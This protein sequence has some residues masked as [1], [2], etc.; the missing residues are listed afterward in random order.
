MPPR[1]GYITSR[2]PHLPETFILREMVELERQGWE[3]RL[4]PLINQNQPI[5]HDEAAYFD[6]NAYHA[7]YLSRKILSSNLRL[8]TRSPRLFTQTWRR[9]MMENIKD[10]KLFVRA[11][12][13]LPKA[14][15]IAQQMQL[16]QVQHIHAH[17]ATHP[18][19]VAWIIH[20]VTGISYSITAHAHDIYVHKAM[21]AT[22]LRDAAFI[23]AISNFNREYMARF[24]GEWVLDKTHV[25]HCGIDPGIFHPRA[26]VAPPSGDKPFQIIHTG[27][28]QPY[29]GQSYLVEACA[30]LMERNINFRCR[31]IGGGEEFSRL[32]SQI[33]KRGL[34]NHVFLEG[35]RK[36]TEVAQLLPD[37]D[38]YVQ[39]SIITTSGKM[40]GI[41]VAL[42]EAM[43]CKLPC[44]AT[45]IS[46]VPELVRHQE[47]GL[48][49]QPAN[50]VDLANALMAI[51][52]NPQ[53]SWQMA[54]AGYNL[55]M[56][57]FCLRENVNSLSDLFRQ[58]IS[59]P[60][61]TIN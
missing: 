45:S 51:Q 59:Y 18:A 29:K 34:Q 33:S 3:V 46:G 30:L 8:M 52:S 44:V 21:L 15:D 10:R 9:V 5:L 1:L 55:V 61:M 42:M 48:L 28:L 20:Q 4:Y 50:S 58:V 43:A 47:T 2:F 39:P 53:W 13:L 31:L 57:E 35:P 27:S 36:Q 54:N 24:A 7:P 14:F 25:I 22:K 38:C 6:K 11:L 16:D 26:T 12:L 41:P 19:L 56:K 40:E 32:S 60:Q 49:V 37:N 23:V 17:Y